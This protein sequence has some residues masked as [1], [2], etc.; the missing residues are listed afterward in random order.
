MSK[1]TKQK[2][3]EITI[4]LFNELGFMQVTLQN[5]ATKANISLGNLTYYF[6]RKDTLINTIY[7]QLVNE[8]RENMTSFRAY[9][10][11]LSID[12]QV[13]AFYRFQQKYRF[14]YVDTLAIERSYPTIAKEHQDHI[15]FQIQ[16]IHNMLLFNIDKGILRSDV[17]LGIYR[18]VAQN[19][20]LVTSHWSRQIELRGKTHEDVENAMAAAVWS[21]L[22]G[23]LTEDGRIS[24][25]EMI[26]NKDIIDARV[27]NIE[28]NGA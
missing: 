9:P 23:F 2:I 28:N 12:Q 8:L 15:N 3:I 26:N 21:L 10:D 20:W 18:Y 4:H 25:S 14:F 22:K 5:I 19:L 24:Y 11:L 7:R 17:E 6:P 13:R 16:D 1:N 27:K